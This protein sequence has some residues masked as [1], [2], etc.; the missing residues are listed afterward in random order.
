MGWRLFRKGGIRSWITGK[1]KC[2]A[3]AVKYF[4]LGCLH[5]TTRQEWRVVL[6]PGPEFGAG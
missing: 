4:S 6:L 5:D 2:W 3:V 1:E